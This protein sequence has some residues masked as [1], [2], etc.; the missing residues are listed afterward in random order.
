MSEQNGADLAAL[1]AETASDVRAFVGSV[2]E[3]AAG[4]APEAALPLLLLVLSQVQVTGARLGAVTDVVPPTRFEPDVPDTADQDA[5]RSSLANL[6]HGIDDYA[7]LV[8]P[9][10]SV[11]IGRG[12]VSDDLA[13]IVASLEQGLAHH[14]SGRLLEALWWWQF[15]YLSEWGVRSSA[16]LRVVQTILGHVRLDA[17][18]DVVA[19]AEFDALH[20]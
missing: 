13:G 5:L 18:E 19:E 7:D 20:P 17:D 2:R 12:A 4:A 8:D 6:L 9:V 11:E 15:G 16:A 10:M 14:D 3:V 1:A